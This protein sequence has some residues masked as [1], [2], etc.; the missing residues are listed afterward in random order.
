MNVKYNRGAFNRTHITVHFLE[1]A[2]HLKITN[3]TKSLILSNSFEGKAFLVAQNK[4]EVLT[5]VANFMAHSYIEATNNAILNVISLFSGE[6]NHV[7]N[8]V[9]ELVRARNPAEIFYFEPNA[10]FNKM[11]FNRGRFQTKKHERIH[12]G[13]KLFG[14]GSVTTVVTFDGLSTLE[15]SNGTEQLNAV[16][17]FIGV[18]VFELLSTGYVVAV[19]TLEGLSELTLENQ[20]YLNVTRSFEGGAYLLIFNS[21]GEFFTFRIETIDLTNL[22]LRAGEEMIINADEKTVMVNGVNVM[23]FL[24]RNSE[25]FN[26]NPNM[27]EVTLLTASNNDEAQIRL[28]WKDAWL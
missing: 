7:M 10:H 23:R 15:M 14:V 5:V 9:A 26:F 19:R 2:T 3:D 8:S 12:V 28:L 6:S 21:S 22:V 4:T 1:G 13:L 16:S 17:S 20:G 24:H 27:N 25:F 18:S 11:R